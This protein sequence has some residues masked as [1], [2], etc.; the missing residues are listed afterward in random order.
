MSV[1]QARKYILGNLQDAPLEKLIPR[2]LNKTYP[3]F[4][5]LCQRVYQEVTTSTEFPIMDW[6]EAIARQAE[7]IV[8]YL[9]D[10]NL[11]P[12]SVE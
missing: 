9:K 12:F 7:S 11:Q 1:N 10:L 4:L 3:S 6:Y 5:E 8:N 2:W